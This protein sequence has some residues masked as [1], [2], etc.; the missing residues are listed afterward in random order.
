[1]PMYNVLDVHLLLSVYDMI[2]MYMYIKANTNLKK[3]NSPSMTYVMMYC[4]TL[5]HVCFMADRGPACN[6]LLHEKFS[7]NKALG[8]V[9]T[10]V[11]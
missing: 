4:Y 5:M 11:M 9:C 6:A 3:E 7:L 8:M 1:M 10:F 2:Y